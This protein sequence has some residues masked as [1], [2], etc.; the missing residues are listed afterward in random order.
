MHSLQVPVERL[1]TTADLI[2]VNCLIKLV[3]QTKPYGHAF[4]LEKMHTGRDGQHA[5]PCQ[6]QRTDV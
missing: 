1:W 6:R 2:D 4:A 3:G 5:G